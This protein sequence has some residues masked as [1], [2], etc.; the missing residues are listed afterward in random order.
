MSITD[1]LPTKLEQITDEVIEL[2]TA[3]RLAVQEIERTPLAERSQGKM[4]SVR[5]YRGDLTLS[6]HDARTLLRAIAPA[7]LV[8]GPTRLPFAHLQHAMSQFVAALIAAGIDRMNADQAISA[9]IE[10]HQTLG[11]WLDAMR[12]KQATTRA[13]VAWAKPAP[14]AASAVMR[15]S[16]APE[17]ER[18]E[19]TETAGTALPRYRAVRCSAPPAPPLRAES[20]GKASKKLARAS[21]APARAQR[22]LLLPIAGDAQNQPAPATKES[23][24]D[25]ASPEPLAHDARRR[26]R[27]RA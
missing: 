5:K 22:A 8:L 10:L 16:T 7:A 18:L 17:P 13:H 9:G 3:L 4:V 2:A 14:I 25:D 24:A 1:T 23:T 12:W 19:N 6:R 26:R 27:R 11:G 20:E 15:Q 21:P